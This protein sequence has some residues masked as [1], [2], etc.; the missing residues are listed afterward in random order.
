[1]KYSHPYNFSFLFSLIVLNTIYLISNKKSNFRKEYTKEYNNDYFYEGTSFIQTSITNKNNNKLSGDFLTIEKENDDQ[2][3]LNNKNN[4]NSQSHLKEGT[5]ISLK[6]IKNTS[7]IN[8][9]SEMQEYLGSKKYDKFFLEKKSKS[10]KTNEKNE[11]KSFLKATKTNEFVNE[12]SEKNRKDD[13]RLKPIPL[14]NYKNTQY[15]GN[16]DI[17]NPPQSIPVIFDTGSGNLWVNSSECKSDA[18]S[19]HKSY[20]RNKSSDFKKIGLG[21]EVTFGSG[22]VDGEIN[23]DTISIGGIEVPNQKFGEIISEQGDVFNDGYFSG[24]LGLAYPEMAAYEAVPIIDSIIN[25]KVLNKNIMSFYYSYDEDSDGQVTIGTIDNTKYT[26]SLDYFD[27]IDK[28][29]WTIKLKDILYN[30]KSLGLCKKFPGGFC[31]AVIDTGTSLIT[32]PTE[33]INYL[34]ESIPVSNDCF[35]FDTAASLSFIFENKDYPEGKEYILD[36]NDYIY[37]TDDGKTCRALMMPLDVPEP[38]G[39]VWILGDV[40]LQKYYSVFDRD[41]N[42]VGFALAKHGENKSIY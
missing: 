18:C 30:G 4:N 29:Y 6:K 34:L 42:N 36:P 19:S 7:L 2:N 27:V 12:V 9:I 21:V 17:G 14:K 37:K 13:S 24:I 35:N 1:M 20:N 38:H 11:N 41:N 5:V 8:F 25:N 22:I 40:F 26:G 28:Y 10:T 15:I 33:D 31:K 16:I 32:G 23:Q 39:P 3:F